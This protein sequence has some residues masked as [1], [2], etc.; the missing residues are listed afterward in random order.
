MRYY[1]WPKQGEGTFSYTEKES[2]RQ[3]SVDYGATTYD[4]AHMPERYVDPSQATKEETKARS[5]LAYHAGVAVVPIR[6]S[7]LEP[8]ATTFATTRA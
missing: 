5:T 7:W 3:H 4:W 6:N 1:Q 2:R 8:Y